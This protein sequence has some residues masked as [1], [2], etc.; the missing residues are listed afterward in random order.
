MRPLVMSDLEQ[1]EGEIC[2]QTY[3]Q[4]TL[5]NYDSRVV[6]TSKLLTFATLDL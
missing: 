5:V 6:V 2:G 1:S 4:F 3:E